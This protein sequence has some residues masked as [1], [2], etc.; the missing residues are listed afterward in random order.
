VP[1]A[2]RPAN[3]VDAPQHV[4]AGQSLDVV[5]KDVQGYHKHPAFLGI[6]KLL[7]L[8]LLYRQRLFI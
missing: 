4:T 6:F 1:R 3:H 8:S 2:P 7:S 5:V